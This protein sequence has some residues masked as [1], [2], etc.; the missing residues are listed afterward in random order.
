M[1]RDRPN[2]VYTQTGILVTD[3]EGMRFLTWIT[4]LRRQS[5]F[6]NGVWEDPILCG[7]CMSAGGLGRM[8]M[9]GPF[10]RTKGSVCI[11][12]PRHSHIRST[13]I[14]IGLYPVGMHIWYNPKIETN[15]I[16]PI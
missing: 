8:S 10:R 2:H 14:R 1:L 13:I 16:L 15:N 6:S 9:S 7:D 3:V 4:L 12:N 11:P 5:K